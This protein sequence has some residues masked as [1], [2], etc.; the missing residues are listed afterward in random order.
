MRKNILAI[1]M[2]IVCC[3][4]YAQTDCTV[5]SDTLFMV[6]VVESETVK[7]PRKVVMEPNQGS[8]WVKD[9]REVVLDTSSYT[10]FF[11]SL[12]QKG[13]IVEYMLHDYERSFGS[14]CTTSF[15]NY[16]SMLEDFFKSQSKLRK[17]GYC[18]RLHCSISDTRFYSYEFKDTIVAN[19][20][21]TIYVE[22]M[23]VEYYKVP[24]KRTEST[25]DFQ[26][27]YEKY[28]FTQ[29]YQIKQIKDVLRPKVYEVPVL[30]NA[31]MEYATGVAKD[32][33]WDKVELYLDD[34]EADKVCATMSYI[35]DQQDKSELEFL[36]ITDPETVRRVFYR[37]TTDNLKECQKCNAIDTRGK[38]VI[39]FHTSDVKRQS[40]FYLNL[41]Y[42][43]I[44]AQK[45]IYYLPNDI[46]LW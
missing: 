15:K 27:D 2:T 39:S 45:K 43:Y 31:E 6:T 10:N 23:V 26:Y 24:Y 1:L 40:V 17:S 35:F 41:N 16:R 13:I 37:M 20:S 4:G 34:L 33:V 32:T 11:D 29:R 7:E 18:N 8:F 14:A 25:T 5:H 3:S 46:K 30:L 44:P 42:V 38:I 28:P 22:K 9:V 12:F 21:V 36:E 19:V